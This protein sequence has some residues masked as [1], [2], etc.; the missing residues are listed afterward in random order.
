VDLQRELGAGDRGRIILRFDE[1][2]ARK[3]GRARGATKL[4]WGRC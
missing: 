2:E 4:G 1:G 3:G